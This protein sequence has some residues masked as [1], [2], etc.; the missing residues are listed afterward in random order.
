M[1][2][3]YTIK[4]G[5]WLQEGSNLAFKRRKKKERRINRSCLRRDRGE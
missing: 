1:K 5:K 4:E 3:H 2:Y